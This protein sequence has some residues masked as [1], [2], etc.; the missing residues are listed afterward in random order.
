M[1]NIG[2]YSMT[3]MTTSLTYFWKALL[4]QTNTPGSLAFTLQS[5]G[6]KKCPRLQTPPSLSSSVIALL[7]KNNTGHYF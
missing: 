6:K 3:S 2:K 4:S 7:P 1:L 5:K